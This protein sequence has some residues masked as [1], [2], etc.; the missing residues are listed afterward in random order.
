MQVDLDHSDKQ[1][2]PS[3]FTLHTAH[4]YSNAQ[5]NSTPVEA[6]AAHGLANAS[7]TSTLGVVGS[8][9]RTRIKYYG[10]QMLTRSYSLRV[11]S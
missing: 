10:Y 5:L 8:Q 9:C 7:L 4:L 6:L 1:S 3:G 11:A 2:V